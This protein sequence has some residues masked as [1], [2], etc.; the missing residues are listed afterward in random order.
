MDGAADNSKLVNAIYFILRNMSR[1]YLIFFEL[2]F[3]LFS[4]PKFSFQ[5]F[6]WN[7]YFDLI[8][9]IDENVN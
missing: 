7:N 5:I 3:I 1:L 6:R 9:T 8:L 4:Y 2:C